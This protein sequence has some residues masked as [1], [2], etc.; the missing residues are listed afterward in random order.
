MQDDATSIL[1]WTAPATPPHV[2]RSVLAATVAP[3]AGAVS[4]GL[5][6]WRVNVR[7]ADQGPGLLSASLRRTRQA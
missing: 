7:P 5:A 6:D 4:V 1:Y 2:K 3:F